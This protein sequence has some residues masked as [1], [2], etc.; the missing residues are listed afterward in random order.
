MYPGPKN[1]K[2]PV[3]RSVG[4]GLS[5]TPYLESIPLWPPLKCTGWLFM[6]E[7][8]TH[9]P[10]STSDHLFL[11]GQ[12]RNRGIRACRKCLIPKVGKFSSYYRSKRTESLLP[13]LI[14]K[15][16]YIVNAAQPWATVHISGPAGCIL[17]YMSLSTPEH[18]WVLRFTLIWQ[19][20][21][22]KSQAP[23]KCGLLHSIPKALDDA[24]E[25]EC[26]RCGSL[27]GLFQQ[28]YSQKWIIILPLNLR[29]GQQIFFF[30]SQQKGHGPL[31]GR[32]K[33]PFSLQGY[34]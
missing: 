15:M 13:F 21:H 12:R 32:H 6:A 31:P 20:Y 28:R 27:S 17:P 19:V 5:T 10:A 29:F 23:K 9:W 34:T 24:G 22:V 3:I 16:S 26:Y 33:K 2:S 25:A 4:W 18:G 30:S 11:L 1:S 8:I 7:N 14:L